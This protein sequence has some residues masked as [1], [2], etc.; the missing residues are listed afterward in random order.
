MR[1]NLL[2]LGFVLCF[3]G[4]SV[5]TISAAGATDRQQGDF[6]TRA[7]EVTVVFGAGSA[8]DNIARVFSDLL[9]QEL[10]RPFPIVN[11]TGG[12]QAIAYNHAVNQRPD[13]YSMIWTSNGL[14][15]AYNLGTLDFNHTAFRNIAR[16]SYEPVA[17][18]VRADAPW[19]TMEEFFAHIS[20]NPGTIRIGNSGA[21]TYTHLVAAALEDKANSTVVHVPFGQ[22]MAFASLLGGQIEASI[23]LPSEAMAQYEANQLRFLAISSAERIGALPNV[24]TFKESNI[25]LEMILWR[26]LAVPR[27]TPDNVV[28]TL[29]NAVRNIVASDEF[30]RFS[31]LA[32]IIPAFMPEDEFEQFLAE[33]NIITRDLMRAIGS[34]VR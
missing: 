17:I 2:F 34:S 9:S 32:S 20:N 21:G 12:G 7:V 26:G 25:D 6:P 4:V 29:E 31:D 5:L 8:A 28:R 10:G 13:G 16:I 22:G 23:Q 11:R 15:T 3:L 30:R 1:K 14:F 33:D 18:A 24:P 27:G 19:R